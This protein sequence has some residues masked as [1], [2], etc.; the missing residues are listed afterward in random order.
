MTYYQEWRNKQPQ[1]K[2]RR[3]RQGWHFNHPYMTDMFH[4]RRWTKENQ[5]AVA[6]VPT[7][8]VA[9]DT[10]VARVPLFQRARNLLARVLRLH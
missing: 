9:V 1:E 10:P 3:L 7:P 6:T 4:Q 2:I 8:Q 5:D